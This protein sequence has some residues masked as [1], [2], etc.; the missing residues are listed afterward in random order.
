MMP[1]SVRMS[2]MIN[3]ARDHSRAPRELPRLTVLV[4]DDES[5]IRWSLR[6]ALTDRGHDVVTA[7]TGGEALSAI[8]GQ[9]HRFDVIVLDYRLPD[10]QDLTLLDEIREQSP[11]SAVVMMTAFGDDNMRMGARRRGARAVVDKPFH[12]KSLVTMVEDAAG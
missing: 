2:P 11:A 8:G 12:V 7:A 3:S 1:E 6:Q 4:V 5:L 10:R 9:G